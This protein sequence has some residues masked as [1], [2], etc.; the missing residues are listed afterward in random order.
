MV[1]MFPPN[2]TNWYSEIGKKIYEK[3]PYMNCW[4]A[5]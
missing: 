2:Y 1:V 3:I 4:R 5:W